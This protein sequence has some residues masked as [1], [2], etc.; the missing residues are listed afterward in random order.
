MAM[1]GSS[2][3][4][5]MSAEALQAGEQE[6]LPRQGRDLPDA[7][8]RRQVPLDLVAAAVHR[9]GIPDAGEDLEQLNLQV[10]GRPDG[11][12]FAHEGLEGGGD[13]GIPRHLA[14]GQGTGIAAEVRQVLDDKLRCRHTR[15]LDGVWNLVA[16]R[17][18]QLDRGQKVP[19]P[20]TRSKAE[21]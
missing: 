10:A 14:A 13:V 1:R 4:I 19:W 21:R 3:M 5:R 7:D 17:R 16:I 11:V 12:G 9:K 15:P 18:V 20:G 8:L 2:S 6:R